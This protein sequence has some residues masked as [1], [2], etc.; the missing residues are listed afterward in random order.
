M[1]YTA[2]CSSVNTKFFAL[3]NSYD[4]NTISSEYASGRKTVILKNTRFPKTIKCSL[5]L[6]VK[7]GEYNAFWTWYTDVLGGLAGTF[8]C[9]ALGSKFYRFKSVP[10]ES[11][12]LL[13]RKIEME[14]EEVY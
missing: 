5:S 11:A 12:G 13:A 14:I 2:W 9:T 8:T 4:E 7:S 3:T 10:S 6:N 1:T